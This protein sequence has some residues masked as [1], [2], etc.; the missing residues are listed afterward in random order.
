[1][2]SLTKLL[3]KIG[4]LTRLS[5][6]LTTPLAFLQSI[7]DPHRSIPLPTSKGVWACE[8][9]VRFGVVSLIVVFFSGVCDSFLASAWRRA[10]F[11]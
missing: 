8:G 7:Y 11:S 9:W 5:L 10:C 1:M 6:E 3:Q 2:Q 4:S